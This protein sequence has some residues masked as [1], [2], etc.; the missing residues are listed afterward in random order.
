M[1]ESLLKKFLTIVSVL[2]FQST[3]LFL[4]M[5]LAQSNYKYGKAGETR[6]FIQ[7]CS[8]VSPALRIQ[9]PSPALKKSIYKEL[10]EQETHQM[11][12]CI[13]NGRTPQS[14]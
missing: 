3:S 11:N 10:I 7:H 14:G 9:K 12:L 13:K 8:R 6:V 1:I 2:P 5:S 4:I